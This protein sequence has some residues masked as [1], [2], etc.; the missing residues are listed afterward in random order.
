MEKPKNLTEEEFVVTLRQFYTFV[1]MVVKISY[2]KTELYPPY[3][4]D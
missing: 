4:F 2:F 1:V 3:L